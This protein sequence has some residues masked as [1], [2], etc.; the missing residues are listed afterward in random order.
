MFK[1]ENFGEKDKKTEEK[2]RIIKNKVVHLQN[3][4][5]RYEDRVK[6]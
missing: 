1:N 6:I 5:I 3:K 4:T 2:I